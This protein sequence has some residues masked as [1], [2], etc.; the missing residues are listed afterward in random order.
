MLSLD[1]NR[2]KHPIMHEEL[3][4]CNMQKDELS[5]LRMATLKAI[6]KEYGIDVSGRRK[7]PYFKGVVSLS[8]SCT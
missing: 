3:Q 8:D 5:L 2:C 1:L 4:L 6:C 7:E